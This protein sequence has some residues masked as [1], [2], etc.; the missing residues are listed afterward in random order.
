MMT[1]KEYVEKL[2]NKNDLVY[3]DT[4]TLMNESELRLFIENYERLF[5]Q[6]E[7]E[8]I[9]PAVVWQ[10]LNQHINSK[11]CNEDK[12]RKATVAMGLIQKHGSLFCLEENGAC[13]YDSRIAFADSIILGRLLM[14]CIYSKQLLITNDRRLSID[15]YELNTQESFRGQLIC[16]C[17]INSRGELHRCDCTKEDA[18]FNGN[19]TGNHEQQVPEND[20]FLTANNCARIVGWVSAATGFFAMGYNVAKHGKTVLNYLK[21]IA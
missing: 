11:P 9:V 18:G 13:S 19:K 8:I 10:E 3:I 2:L 6:K 15:A 12:R 21:R 4:S 7:K 1:N 16:V 20:S 5:L 14:E 17:Y